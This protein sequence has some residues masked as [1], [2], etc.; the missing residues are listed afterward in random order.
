LVPEFG[1]SIA[2]STG[3]S[4]QIS[5]FDAA[6]SWSAVSSAGGVVSISNAGL[7][8][9]SG[10]GSGVSSSLTVSTSRSGYSG[11]SAVI[12]FSTTV[13]PPQPSISGGLEDSGQEKFVLMIEKLKQDAQAT[14]DSAVVAAVVLGAKNVSPFKILALS[15]IQIT[16]LP[17][18]VFAE[19]PSYALQIFNS[20]QVSR[21]N[22]DQFRSIPPNKIWALRSS[23]VRGI[24]AMILSKLSV[25]QLRGLTE[26]QIKVLSR[27]QLSLL[28][29]KQLR[30]LKG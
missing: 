25:Q 7:V 18:K 23:A 8:Q 27:S 16:Q 28:T 2:N 10:L 30:A 1:T 20:R 21:F 9:V 4:L 17:A 11:G 13:P 29:G 15:D 24:S 14:K 3:F 19:L 22:V 26:S 5:N 6:Y 12:P